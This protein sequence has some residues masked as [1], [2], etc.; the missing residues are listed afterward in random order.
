VITKFTFLRKKVFSGNSFACCVIWYFFINIRSVTICYCFIKYCISLGHRFY[1]TALILV[2]W[3]AVLF[4]FSFGSFST[5]VAAELLNVK[6][7]FSSDQ[8]WL[9]LLFCGVF[10]S[11]LNKV[12]KVVS[13][14]YL[15]M[16][17]FLRAWWKPAVLSSWVILA[18]IFHFS[19]WS[20][21]M[22]WESQRLPVA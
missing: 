22:G 5:L 6:A 14:F 3:M 1:L 16:Q 13:G 19:P 4:K 2:S 12:K 8:Y 20:N 18:S 7:C 15:S 9:L 17:P 11:K 21:F 10:A